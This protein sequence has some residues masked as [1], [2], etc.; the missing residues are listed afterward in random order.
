MDIV[1]NANNQEN[2]Q[3]HSRY[4]ADA[5]IALGKCPDMAI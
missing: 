5:H 1:L 2:H 4:I 3:T